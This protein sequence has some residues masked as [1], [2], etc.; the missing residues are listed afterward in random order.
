MQ[1]KKMP[2]Q[3]NDMR[4]LAAYRQLLNS[5]HCLVAYTSDT[6]KNILA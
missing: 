5:E 2:L 3:C 6:R 4:A 1:R